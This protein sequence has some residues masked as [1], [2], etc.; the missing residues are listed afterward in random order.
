MG[1]II[2]TTFARNPYNL[3]SQTPPNLKKDNYYMHTLQDKVDADWE[4]R[5]NK[6]DVERE[7]T[8]GENDYTPLEV[9]IQTIRNDKGEKVSDNIRRLVFRDIKYEAPIGTKFRFSYNFDL[10]EPNEDKNV[11]LT[12]NKNSASPT[13]ASVVVRCNG[14]IASTYVDEDGV[15]KIH[16]EEIYSSTNLSSTIPNFNAAIVT[17]KSDLTILAQHNKYTRNYYVNQR[18]I[19]GYNQVYK[20]AAIQNMDSLYTYKADGAGLIMLYVNLDQI[21]EYDNFENRLAYNGKDEEVNPSQPIVEGEYEFG[22]VEPK[23]LPTE[24]YSDVIV[25]KAQLSVDG[26]VV[27]GSVI[28]E[29]VLAINGNEDHLYID[30]YVAMEFVNGTNEFKLRRKKVINKNLSVTVSISAENPSGKPFE[31]TFELFLGGLE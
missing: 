17:A 6:V 12:A 5:P 7:Q 19:V 1:K 29:P 8:I 27:D 23:P 9:V 24:L 25:F 2:D 20:V 4:Y 30:R 13:E 3:I 26:K 16:Y 31:Q 11:W 28:Q 15:N 10:D 14:T 21:S 22:V 18:F